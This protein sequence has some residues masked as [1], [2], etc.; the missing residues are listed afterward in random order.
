MQSRDNGYDRNADIWVFHFES[1][2][3]WA[4]V[5]TNQEVGDDRAIFNLCSTHNGIFIL[6]CNCYLQ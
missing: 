4:T 1:V 5:L 3:T 6:I 2:V